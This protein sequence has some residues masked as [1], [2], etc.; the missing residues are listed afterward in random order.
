MISVYGNTVKNVVNQIGGRKTAEEIKAE[1]A[2]CVSRKY[3][4][5]R[6]Q[7]EFSPQSLL[8]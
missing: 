1:P 3:E 4:S 6:V 2:A 8:P 5:S 7:T